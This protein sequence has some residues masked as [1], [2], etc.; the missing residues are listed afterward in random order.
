MREVTTKQAM[1]LLK[2]KS[3]SLSKLKKILW[4]AFSL[5][6]RTRDNF[7]C[8]TCGKSKATHP[9]KVYQAGHLF[10]RKKSAII[11]H[12]L[13]VHCQCYSCN[14]IHNSDPDVY[15]EKFKEKYGIDKYNELYNMR[16]AM[17][18]R[19]KNDIILL[20][21]YFKQKLEEIK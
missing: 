16:N 17:C 8:F 12:E 11:Y 14:T 5:Y 18:I 21:E 1:K 15:R 9:D 7:T 6:I 10:S 13:N 4:D 19:K 2:K 3:P 20:T